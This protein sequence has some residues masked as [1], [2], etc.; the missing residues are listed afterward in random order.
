MKQ[1]IANKI[2]ICAS[3]ICL[4]HC[5]A[6]PIIL[7]FF[8]ALSLTPADHGDHSHA[9]GSFHEIFAVIVVSSVLIAIYPQCKRHG[10]KDI[11]FYALV[12]VAFILGAVFLGHGLGE[13]YEVGM[14]ITGSIFMILAHMKNM[15]VR[16]G[17]CTDS[18]GHEHSH[19]HSHSSETPEHIH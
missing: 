12:G 3:T 6:T 14:T 4:I 1:F 18:H 9:H 7:L 15:K 19:D 5:I 11:V 8:P 2:G 17:R 16:H 13:I 10:H